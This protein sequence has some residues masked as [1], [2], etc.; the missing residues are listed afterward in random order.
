M[1]YDPEVLW[2]YEL[3]VKADFF[4][5]RLRINGALFYMDWSDMQ[6]EFLVPQLEGTAGGS[7]ISNAKSATSKGLELSLSALPVD[8]L[9]VN[10]N[11]GYLRA[12]LGEATIFIRNNVCNHR[13]PSTECNHVL[14]GKTTPLSPK[15]TMSA[16]AEYSFP[17]YANNEGF[18]RL[19]WTF[20]DTVETTLVEGLIQEKGFPWQVPSYDFFN[21]RAGVRRKDFSIVA[22]AENLF[23]SNY[24]ANAYVKAWAGGVALEPS[25]RT[26][27]I[28]VQYKYGE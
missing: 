9:R 27:G 8:N 20:R 14:D 26:Y 6:V 3:G 25:F 28:R 10:F 11:V 12:Q 7:I 13:P 23:N 19:E 2:N 17:I 18:A 4:D 1:P 16:D 22:Y 21:L 15:W 24:Y 5:H